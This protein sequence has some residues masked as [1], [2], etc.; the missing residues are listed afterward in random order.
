MQY[1]VRCI[2]R[3]FLFFLKVIII[4]IITNSWRLSKRS[5]KRQKV[6]HSRA[7]HDQSLLLYCISLYL[8]VMS[9]KKATVENA[10]GLHICCTNGDSHATIMTMQCPKTFNF[11]SVIVN[12]ESLNRL[13]VDM[14]LDEIRLVR[15]AWK[16]NYSTFY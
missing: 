6:I 14:V 3:S 9:L 4:F 16:I 10:K 15:I 1:L 5:A 11:C 7:V 2:V 13:C 12:H 8:A